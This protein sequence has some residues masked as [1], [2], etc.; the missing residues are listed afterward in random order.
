MGVEVADEEEAVADGCAVEVIM[1]EG[2][3]EEA[4]KKGSVTTADG[5]CFG[6]EEV[7]VDREEASIGNMLVNIQCWAGLLWNGDVSSFM[8]IG[9]PS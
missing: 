7:S 5:V 2:V 6:T 4:A 1:V 8:N 3:V 9:L